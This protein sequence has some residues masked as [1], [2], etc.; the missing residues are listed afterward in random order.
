MKIRVRST[1]PTSSTETV[2]S[3]PVKAFSSPSSSSENSS[4]SQ[5][6][7]KRTPPPLP[8][9]PKLPHD[10]ETMLH[11]AN[12]EASLDYSPDEANNEYNSTEGFYSYGSLRRP[13]RKLTIDLLKGK[14]TVW[15]R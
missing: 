14:L 5:P 3:T 7:R 11:R 2:V 12:Y 6:R 9:K 8:P 13:G 1:A 15:F 10:I 4:E